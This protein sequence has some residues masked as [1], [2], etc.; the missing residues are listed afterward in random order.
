MAVLA[1]SKRF[2][3]PVDLRDA[4]PA[5]DTVMFFD[6]NLFEWNLEEEK[7]QKLMI[8]VRAKVIY[9]FVGAYNI[10][11]REAEGQGLMD[12]DYFW[13]DLGLA[14]SAIAVKLSG[15]KG[16]GFKVS[17]TA[18]K[19]GNI[20][21]ARF[22]KLLR[23]FLK[24]KAESPFMEYLAAGGQIKLEATWCETSKM[25]VAKFGHPKGRRR[26]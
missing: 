23:A 19:A 7:P 9:L 2:G 18:N 1:V 17:P 25:L 4:D 11:R 24:E 5:S 3:G 21:C 12:G 8:T 20:F 26:K 10:L 14:P 13:V 16:R 15:K 22:I 6:P